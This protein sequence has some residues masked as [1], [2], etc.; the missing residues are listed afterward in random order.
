MISMMTSGHVVRAPQTK[1]TRQGS[2][3]VTVLLSTPMA[4]DQS[5]LVNVTA[6]DSDLCRVLAGVRK[7]EDMTV[8]GRATLGIYEGQNGPQVSVQL[9]ATRI[10][11]MGE[12]SAK[13]R[14]R[15]ASQAKP[16]S[17]QYDPR[18]LHGGNGQGYPAEDG[19]DDEVPF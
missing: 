5:Q 12:A 4:G 8:S 16:D 11:V 10:M 13:P 2:D 19:F 1:Q 14:S 3:F 6:F 17:R 9:T 7:G 15:K 18:D